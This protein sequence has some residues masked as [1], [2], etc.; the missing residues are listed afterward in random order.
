MAKP[1]GD[2]KLVQI[3]AGGASVP[4]IGTWA[5]VVEEKQHVYSKLVRSNDS[6]QLFLVKDCGF[7]GDFADL[8]YGDNSKMMDH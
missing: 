4:G 3:V 1:T 6:V 8:G 2:V 7:F 5:F